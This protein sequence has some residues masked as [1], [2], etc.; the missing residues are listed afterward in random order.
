MKV[1][2]VIFI[3]MSVYTVH[4]CMGIPRLH[5]GKNHWLEP[6][7]VYFAWCTR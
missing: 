4:A 3:Q 2:S 1:V 7:V 5:T 6:P